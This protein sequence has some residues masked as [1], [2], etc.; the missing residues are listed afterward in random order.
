MPE[1]TKTCP[2]CAETILASAR[3]CKHCGEMLDAKPVVIEQTG[4]KYKREMALGS[5]IAIGGVVL[6]IFSIPFE[7]YVVTLAGVLMVPLGLLVFIAAR[8]RAWW[9]HG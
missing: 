2:L 3:K 9:H 7:N 5:G 8:A 1:A 6:S 4:K